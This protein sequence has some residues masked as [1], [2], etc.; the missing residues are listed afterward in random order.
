MQ[1]LL[2]FMRRVSSKQGLILNG[3][4]VY[5]SCYDEVL[6][7]FAEA[8]LK[9]KSDL[10]NYDEELCKRIVSFFMENYDEIWT[11]P[12]SLR[13]EVEERVSSCHQMFSLKEY[14]FPFLFNLGLSIT[15]K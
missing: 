6:D 3:L 4:N 8:I 9:P 2:K 13:K 11:P 14:S 5:K 12:V 7:T 15:R 10:A 1:L